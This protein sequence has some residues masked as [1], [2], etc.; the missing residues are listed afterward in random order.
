[1]TKRISRK[2]LLATIQEFE[3]TCAIAAGTVR[4]QPSSTVKKCRKFLTKLALADISCDTQEPFNEWLD[5][6]TE[7]LRRKLPKSKKRR[8]RPKCKKPWGIARKALNVFLR[9][10]LYNR[11]LC[12][13]NRLKRIEKWLEIPLDSIVAKKLRQHAG[14]GQLPQWPGLQDLEQDDSAQFQRHA[15]EYAKELGLP[16]R[17]FL[18]N[19]LWLQGR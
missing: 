17:V 3:A 4:G 10:C 13:E 8:K 15:L 1:M 12:E 14:R 5:E 7:S 6:Q 9:N 2:E 11:F 19:I 16:A 18:D